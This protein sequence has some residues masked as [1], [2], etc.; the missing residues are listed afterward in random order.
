MRESYAFSFTDKPMSDR[1]FLKY[2]ELVAS[3]SPPKLSP[4]QLRTMI[5]IYLRH[6][7]GDEDFDV[8]ALD[9]STMAIEAEAN[10]NLNLAVGPEDGV[11]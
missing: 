3:F 2:I 4:Q 7:G 6:Y 9:A 8:I 10:F 11:H 5:S 1:D